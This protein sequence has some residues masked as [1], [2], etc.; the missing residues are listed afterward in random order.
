MNSKA[1]AA[2]RRPPDI[3]GRAS[4]GR[5]SG[6]SVKHAVWAV[7]PRQ[8]EGHTVNATRRLEG[9]YEQPI[10]VCLP[11]AGGQGIYGYDE[12]NTMWV[13]L[14]SVEAEHEGRICGLHQHDLG[15]LV[16]SRGSSP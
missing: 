16:V 3:G 5:P 4:V 14:E 1:G 2:I 6:R 11:A 10:T 15:L 9:P 8:Y 13:E 7:Y 12:A